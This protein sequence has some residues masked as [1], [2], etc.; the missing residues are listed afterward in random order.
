MLMK[1]VKDRLTYAHRYVNS[2]SESETDRQTD[3]QTDN[4]HVNNKYISIILF[5]SV[6]SRHLLLLTPFLLLLLRSV[7]SII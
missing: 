4:E 1:A 6:F 5:I 3:R 2:Y 7:H